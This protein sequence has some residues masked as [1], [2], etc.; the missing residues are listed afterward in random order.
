MKGKILLRFL[1]VM[2]VLMGSLWSIKKE[3]M[4]L[5]LDLKGG[6]YAVLEADSRKS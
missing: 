5:G 2:I 1:L 3:P 6:V 4:K